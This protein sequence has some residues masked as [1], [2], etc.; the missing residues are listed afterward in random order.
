M[1]QLNL[2]HVEVEPAEFAKVEQPTLDY[3]FGRKVTA[4]VFF[5][6]CLLMVFDFADRMIIASILPYIQKD[7]GISDAQAGLLSS[8]LTLGMVLFAFPVSLLI[9]RYGRI[10]VASLMGIFW[11]IASALG[12]F[13]SS[14]SQLATTRLFVGIGEAA[15]APA[16]YSWISSAFPRRRLQLAL[17]IFSASQPIGMAVGIAFGG[18]VAQHYGWRHALG[19]LTL[20]GIVVAILLYR[21]RD[22]KSVLLPKQAVETRQNQPET[23]GSAVSFALTPPSRWALLK[24]NWDTI[25]HTPSLLLIYVTMAVVTLQWIPVVFFLPS[26]LHRVHHLELAQASLMTSAFLLVGIITLPLGGWVLD[27]LTHRFF[28]AKFYVSLVGY[29]LATVFYAIAFG[30]LTD[31]K[32]QFSLIVLAGAVLSFCSSGPLSLT[33]EL[34]PVSARTLSGT[35]SVMT[36]HLLGSIPGPFIAGLISDT[37][38]I[39][40]ALTVLPII[41]GVI[42][43]GL[44]AA[45]L[46]FY[47]KDIVKV[48][49]SDLELLKS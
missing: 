48:K 8:I 14:F 45:A 10:K 41:S 46:Y 7:W 36:I 32:L 38:G 29:A 40:A 15:Y 26:Y 37:Y 17:G 42:A 20:P 30:F 24:Q 28:K 9:E 43:L 5:L 2:K 49:H 25:R 21:G 11:G 16:S 33:Q 23:A 44:L 31:L 27:Q 39:S 34:V 3:L 13:S 4:K 6:L 19:L 47:P 35:T 1:T 22:Y 12:A 18:Y